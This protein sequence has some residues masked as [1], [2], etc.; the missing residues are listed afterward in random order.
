MGYRPNECNL[1]GEEIAVLPLGRMPRRFN[2]IGQLSG[3]IAK[4]C[5]QSGFR[6]H[7]ELNST[8][9]KFRRIEK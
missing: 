2:T 4:M 5:P 3:T 1:Y 9:M 6:S 8:L 7:P